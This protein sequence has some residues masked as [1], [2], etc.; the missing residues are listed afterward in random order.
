MWWIYGNLRRI[1]G[2]FIATP[3]E[4]PAKQQLCV[5]DKRSN[6]TLDKFCKPAYYLARILFETKCRLGIKE[7]VLM[8]SSHMRMGITVKVAR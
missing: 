5:C 2:V 7:V 6:L 8:G 3:N 4:C 1:C